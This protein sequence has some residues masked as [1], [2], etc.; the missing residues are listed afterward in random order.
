MLWS[1]V[2]ICA[3]FGR[4]TPSPHSFLESQ[5]WPPGII[6][7]PEAHGGLCWPCREITLLTIQFLKYI[8]S[9][10]FIRQ[11]KWKKSYNPLIPLAFLM[12][13][14][15]WS[16]WGRGPFCFLSLSSQHTTRCLV[17]NL[18]S[19]N[20]LNGFLFYPHENLLKSPDQNKHHSA[21]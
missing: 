11:N 17:Y 12:I 16:S 19:V 10:I 21:L 18:V 5:N 20:V 15:L 14:T 8:C 7:P 9:I 3:V 1:R 6:L 2:R 4:V 13:N